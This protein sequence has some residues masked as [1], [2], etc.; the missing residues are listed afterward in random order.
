[1]SGISVA[2]HGHLDDFT[3]PRPRLSDQQQNDLVALKG[4]M[5]DHEVN[6]CAHPL[7]YRIRLKHD[8]WFPDLPTPLSKLIRG[9]STI[10]LLPAFT[11]DAGMIGSTGIL[12]LADM[13]PFEDQ[14]PL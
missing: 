7:L 3:E 13:F 4:R 9:E 8:L 5:L 12:D 10:R 6:G 14:H 1:M 2:T 11:P